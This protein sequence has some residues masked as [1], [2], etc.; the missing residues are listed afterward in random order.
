MKY[1]VIGLILMMASLACN[2]RQDYVE[3]CES[4]GYTGKAAQ[5]CADLSWEGKDMDEV[6][7]WLQ[8]IGLV[9]RSG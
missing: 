5:V 3:R 8:Y 9:D 6:D 7:A 2:V 1:V 4:A